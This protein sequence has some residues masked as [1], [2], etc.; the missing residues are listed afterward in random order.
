M[1]AEAAG[2]S[3]G[4]EGD[5]DLEELQA[6]V[7]QLRAENARLKATKAH[8]FW[9]TSGATTLIVIGV[10]LFTLAISASWLSNTILDEDQWVATV[11]PLAR[12]AAIQDYVATEASDAF[13]KAIDVETNVKQALEA[14]PQEARGLLLAPITDGIRNFAKDAAFKF[15]RSPQFPELWVSMN[16]LAHKAFIASITQTSGGTITN[17]D[18]KVTLEVGMLIDEVKA[19]LTKSGLGFVNSIP[20]PA[21]DQKVTLVDSPELGRY[22]ALIRILEE[23]AYLLPALAVILLAAG[24]ALAPNRRKAVFWMGFGM[25]V[26]TVLPLQAVYLGRFPFAKAALELGDM[27]STAAQH[28]Y[29]IVFR[30]LVNANQIGAFVGLVFLLGAI[31]VGPGKWAAALRSAVKKALDE[32]WPNRGFGLV[33]QWIDGHRTGIRAAGAITAILSLL[34]M[35]PKSIAEVIWLVIALLVWLL[36][37]EVFGRPTPADAP[38]VSLDQEIGEPKGSVG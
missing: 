25:I 5:A 3:A 8:G 36:A 20:I 27:P 17:Q 37:V 24:V 38:P 7:D 12:D 35:P 31:A 28:A 13:L 11:A 22:S 6:E 26:V 4:A 16:R 1:I 32:A 29:N 33:G 19:E 21:T 2:V 23:E 14:L 18:G 10:L 30:E 15:V 9:R 34:L